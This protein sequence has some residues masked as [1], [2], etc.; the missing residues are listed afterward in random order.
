M[1]KYDLGDERMDKQTKWVMAFPAE[2][3]NQANA[4]EGERQ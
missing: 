3:R 2:G 1:P 4:W